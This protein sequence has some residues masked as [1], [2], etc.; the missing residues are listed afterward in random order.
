MSNTLVKLKVKKKGEI[1]CKL[2]LSNFEWILLRTDWQW[3]EFS[4]KVNQNLPTQVITS[5]THRRRIATQWKQTTT[6]S[7]FSGLPYWHFLSKVTLKKTDTHLEKYDPPLK[8]FPN[9]GGK[10]KR[11]GTYFSTIM[12]TNALKRITTEPGSISFTAYIRQSVLGHI[13]PKYGDQVSIS[14]TLNVHIFCTNVFFLVAF[15][16]WTNF[17]TKNLCI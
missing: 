1:R 7:F 16:L 17:C 10:H 5:T 9:R 4:F 15:R 11:G 2:D 8:V 13:S 3:F 12:Q 14:S 6:T